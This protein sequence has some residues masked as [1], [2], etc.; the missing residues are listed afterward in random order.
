MRGASKF[1]VRCAE[2]LKFSV[3]CAKHP[4]FSVRC[5]ERPQAERSMREAS[6]VTLDVRSVPFGRLRLL[7]LPTVDDTPEVNFVMTCSGGA[8]GA[9]IQVDP[10]MTPLRE[11]QISF[12]KQLLPDL[13]I[14]ELYSN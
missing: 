13:V 10:P 4:K 11:R 7:G 2:R 14:A 12:A 8:T 9:F 6:Q 5:A 3:R 1:N